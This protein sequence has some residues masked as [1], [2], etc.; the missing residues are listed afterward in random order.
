MNRRHFNRLG[1]LAAAGAFAPLARAQ[2][3]PWPAHEIQVL[4]PV[5]P[6][7]A[8]DLSARAVLTKAGQLL[9]AT[10]VVRNIA[11]GGGTL[12]A[13]QLASA[14]PDGYTIGLSS[15]GAT[16]V[17]PH[18]MK[19]PYSLDNFDLLCSYGEGMYGLAVGADSPVKSVDDLVKLAKT[20]RVTVSANAIVN[21]VSVLQIGALTGAN[22]QWVAT[23]TQ[24]EA[25]AQA[26]GGHVDA[27]LQSAPDLTALAESGK[28]RLLASCNDVRWPT[29]PEMKTLKELGYDAQNRVPYGLAAPK[30]VDPAI[31]ARLESAIVQAAKDPEVVKQMVGLG[32]I[33]KPLESAAFTSAVHGMAPVIEKMMTDAGL[34]KT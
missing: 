21:V 6:G 7:G 33:S 9:T 16:L 17:A 27:V 10:F 3:K 15:I 31:R 24:S 25:V 8:A 26:A 4:I 20:R 14:K 2:G 34:K 13:A 5:S 12:G 32:V 18:L 11:G 29:M 30:G 22:F 28:L 19:L 23:N 1:A